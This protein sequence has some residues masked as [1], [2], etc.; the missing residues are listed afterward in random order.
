MTTPI[1]E[2]CIITNVDNKDSDPDL[3]LPTTSDRINKNVN[4]TSNV[5]QRTN[6][7]SI[8]RTQFPTLINTDVRDLN[9]SAME[10]E[11]DPD[12]ASRKRPLSAVASD[13]QDKQGNTRA[14][15]P[16]S[17]ENNNITNLKDSST[18]SGNQNNKILYS[19]T[20]RP[21]Y[22]I[23]VYSHNT[24]PS[25]TPMH[26]LLISRTLSHIAYADIKEIKRIG[27]G[28]I[29]A[30]M[31]SVN[32]ANNLVLNPNL[33]K[34]NLRAFIPSY[35]TVRTGIVK[36]IPQHFEESDLM[37]F[38]D[39]PFKVV[40]VKRLN[41]RLKIN[42]EIKYVPSRTICL[43]FAGQILPKYVFLCRN[44]Y[45]VFPYVSKVKLCFSCQRIGHI[46]K[47]CKGKPRCL[48]CGDE[49]HD[50]PS[51]CPKANDSDTP[52]C[53]NCQ[54]EH[55]ATSFECPLIIKHKKF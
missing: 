38:F 9:D 29:L 47:N 49:K 8:Q 16:L 51:S 26:P 45:D 46:S 43:K 3:F 42:G 14:K 21:P 39:S 34:N 31:N 36:D 4:L 5:T 25:I 1:P 37:Q 30:E 24:D 53:I 44:R 22:I 50:S 32:A 13:K 35:R 54:G 23:H 10:I 52:T 11:T 18:D 20:D 19:N 41:R 28:K 33:E 55:L 7:I 17:A 6:S 12:A 27:R 48:Y 15:K 40:E 2:D